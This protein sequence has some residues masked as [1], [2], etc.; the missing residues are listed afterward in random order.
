LE[1]LVR[2][3][4]HVP[5]FGRWDDLL[6]FDDNPTMQNIAFSI[7]NQGLKANNGLCAKWM[8]RKGPI[9]TQLRQHLKLTPK[10]YRKLLVN[11]T[12]VVESQMCAKQWDDINFNHV[13][14]IASKIYQNAF[15]KHQETRYTAWQA[16][17]KAGKEGVKINATAIFPHDVLKGLT[18]GQEE[19]AE[20]QWLAL[21]NYLN[22]DFG[23]LAMVDTS[24]SMTVPIT[25]NKNLR[26]I[27]ISVSLGL[28]IAEKQLGAFHGEVL[29]F[30][31]HP[32]IFKLEG[33]LKQRYEMLKE[34]PWGGNTNLVGAVELL[35]SI[36]IRR[37]A[38]Q[39]EMPKI[40]LV[41]SDMQF[42]QY[43]NNTA[44]EAIAYKYKEAGYKIPIIVFWNLNGE[45]KNVPAT[46]NQSG[47]VMVSGYSPT[48]LK[49]ILA[50]E[51]ENLS[52]YSI[53][54]TVINN[55]RYAVIQ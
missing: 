14:S 6:I 48:V 19:T 3:L 26:A 54:M 9:A 16:D 33:T 49:A 2:N 20:A 17:L 46:A 31:A 15:K 29:N 52:P 32:E 12:K 23:I 10:A 39:E 13:P 50:G 43:G 55:P 27:D 37:E 18:A 40:L 1:A 5:E 42:D 44:V 36:A 11:M 30:D 34:L 47:I 51:L 35:L 7:I 45:Y 41:L 22:S 21:P 24:G 38:K 53:M 4:Q 25:G 28:Y 8:P